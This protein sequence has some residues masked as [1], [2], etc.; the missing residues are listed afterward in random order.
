MDRTRRPHRQMDYYYTVAMVLCWQCRREG[1]LPFP[2]VWCQQAR[3]PR[4][5]DSISCLL[6]KY[7]CTATGTAV[8]LKLKI[9][10]CDMSLQTVESEGTVAQERKKGKIEMTYGQKTALL[11]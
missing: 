11:T 9:C 8:D 5:A 7:S 1:V 10:E 6:L 2:G 3:G 4:T